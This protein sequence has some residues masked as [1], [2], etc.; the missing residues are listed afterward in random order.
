MTF[1]GN[2]DYASGL[3]VLVV[4]F[5]VAILP[6]GAL[7]LPDSQWLPAAIAAAGVIVRFA[8]PRRREA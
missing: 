1:S 2:A 4:A 3:A 8:I 5:V 7:G 6:A